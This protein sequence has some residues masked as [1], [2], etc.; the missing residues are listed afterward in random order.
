MDKNSHGPADSL[1]RDRMRMKVGLIANP[2]SGKD[3]RRI[4]AHGSVFD[5]QEKVRMVR[6]ILT[7]LREAGVDEVLFMP[8][9]YAIVER[10]LL[11][12]PADRRPS[13]IEPLVY[14]QHN[15][16]E[17]TV[18]AA[19]LLEEAGAAVM[20][21]LGGDGTARAA[22][23][24]SR[25]LP[26]LALSTGTNNVFPVMTEATVAGL[27]A[28]ILASGALSMDEGCYEADILEILVNDEVRDLALVD[29]AVAREAFV[30][31]RAVWDMERI[32]A[33]FLA[34]CKADSIGLSAIGG[35]IVH[36][37][38]ASGTGLALN[39]QGQAQRTVRATIAPG[40]FVSAG[41]VSHS[42]MH[43]GE[44]F[45]VEQSGVLALDGERDLVLHKKDTACVRLALRGVQVVDVPK[46][47]EA[48]RTKGLFARPIGQAL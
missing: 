9:S 21:V 19:E 16:Q 25:N 28:G 12:L 2:A 48:A 23:R 10:A 27:A 32:S 45:A 11:D 20:I 26:I 4:V 33:L 17:D 38:P 1:A 31:S 18:R 40:L 8:D 22:C 34:R 7:G 6:R 15:T 29:V 43:K 30:G 36:C 37:A 41:I 44:T 3:I 35:Q 46:T 14:W 47:L 39:L 42:I 13:S 24:G 5:N